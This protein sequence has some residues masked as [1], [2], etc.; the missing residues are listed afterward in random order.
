VT[1]TAKDGQVAPVFFEHRMFRCLLQSERCAPDDL[2][3]RS[4]SF[5]G[6]SFSFDD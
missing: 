4:A 6:K 3:G 2:V 5:D 1:L